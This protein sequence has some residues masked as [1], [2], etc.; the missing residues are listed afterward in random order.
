MQFAELSWF[1][2]LESPSLRLT[3]Q[4]AHKLLLW[5]CCHYLL[6]LFS[7][8]LSAVFLVC[9][10]FHC[11]SP[12]CFRHLCYL[13]VNRHELLQCYCMQ[14]KVFVFVRLSQLKVIIN[15]NC[16]VSHIVLASV[17]PNQYSKLLLN[18]LHCQIL[19]TVW[20]SVIN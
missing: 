1:F 13:L 15:A 3:V 9:L 17:V 7:D 5:S 20:A 4:I 14:R 8:T 2:G 18:L 16:L 19:S 10:L 6:G 11:P 12:L